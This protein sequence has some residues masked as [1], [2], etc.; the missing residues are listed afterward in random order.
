MYDNA[1]DYSDES[2]DDLNNDAHAYVPSSFPKFI[3]EHYKNTNETFHTLAA[4]LYL[5]GGLVAADY[6]KSHGLQN[7][8]LLPV[9]FFADVH[10]CLECRALDHNTKISGVAYLFSQ[11]FEKKEE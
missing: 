4:D 3:P 2:W 6:L 8:K 7:V 10:D 11:Y 5:R 1:D 9:N